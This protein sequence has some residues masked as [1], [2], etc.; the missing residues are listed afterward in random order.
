MTPL[1]F[2][3]FTVDLSINC[4]LQLEKSLII[5]MRTSKRTRQTDNIWTSGVN[6][7]MPF[8]YEHVNNELKLWWVN[9]HWTLVKTRPTKHTTWPLWRSCWE[10]SLNTNLTNQHGSR[11]DQD[12]L[13]KFKLSIRIRK[14]DDFV[15]V[16]TAWLLV[17]SETEGLLGFS[18][19]II[20]R[21]YRVWSKKQK[22]PIEFIRWKFL[23]HVKSQTDTSNL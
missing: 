19:T 23:V 22:I 20:F 15:T 21:V 17:F 8:M 13:L 6:I 11:H 12:Y 18:Q 16:N 4:L 10:A 9:H 7:G 14:K 3:C 1:L 5:V 2:C